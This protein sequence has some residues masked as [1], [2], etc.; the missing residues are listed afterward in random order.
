MVA[1]SYRFRLDV[2]PDQAKLFSYLDDS[3]PLRNRLALDRLHNRELCKEQKHQDNSNIHF[4]DRADQY[5]AV[6]LCAETSGPWLHSWVRQN[7]ASKVDEGCK[8][9][10]EGRRVRPSA[11]PH[12]TIG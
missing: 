8:R 5:E 12:K 10:F 1:H 6:S 11:Y 9:L 7:S 2:T 4:Y 3:H